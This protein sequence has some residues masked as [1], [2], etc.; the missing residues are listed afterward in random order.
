[1]SRRVCSRGRR[2]TKICQAKAQVFVQRRLM[3]RAMS[4]TVDVSVI[5]ALARGVN[6]QNIVP[7]HNPLILTEIGDSPDG[8]GT[9]LR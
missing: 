8:V 3:F 1:M 4:T 6:P 5:Q 7:L 9:M 2:A